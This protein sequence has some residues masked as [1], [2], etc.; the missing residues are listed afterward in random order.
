MLLAAAVP[1]KEA[2]RVA[3]LHDLGL[4]DTPDEPAF[5]S[6]VQL[7]AHVCN[8]P[9]ALVSLVDEHRQWFKA[10]IGFDV[11]ETAREV[12]FCTY[13]ILENRMLEVCD[14]H[15]DPRFADN[16]LVTGTSRFRFYAGVPIHTRDGIALGTVCVI[17]LVPRRLDAD[18]RWML[19]II[20]EQVTAQIELRRS[21]ADIADALRARDDERVLLCSVLQSATAYGLI[22]TTPNGTINVFSRG[23]EKLLG[24]SADEVVGRATP[25]LF[26]LEDEVASRAA[27]LGVEDRFE[28]FVE[29]ARRGEGE[30]QEWTW[31]RKD[32]SRLPVGLTVTAM[33]NEANKL[34]GFIGIGQDL[35]EERRAALERQR[36]AEE[37]RA[38]AAAD[39]AVD[40]LTRLQA[41]AAALIPTMTS[42]QV[43]EIMKQQ[44]SSIRV[45]GGAFSEE[46]Q[47]FL[48][49]LEHLGAQALDRA[50]AHEA[51]S[52]AHRATEAA[53]H[54]KEEF[55]AVLSHELRT[56]LTAVLGWAHLLRSSPVPPTAIDAARLQRGL[57][58]IENNATTLLGAVEAILDVQRIVAG[59]IELSC[60]LVDLGARV[61]EA[62]DAVKPVAEAAGLTLTLSIT[63]G[64]LPIR[65]DPARLQQIVNNLLANAIKFTPRGGRIDVGVDHTDSQLRLT[66]A[67]TGEG[68]SPDFLPRMFE[69]GLQADSSRTRAHG[70]LG[71]GLAIVKHLVE[72]HGGTVTA[73]SG[74]LGQ[75]ARVTVLLPVATLG[76]G[77]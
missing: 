4:L 5:D 72:L 29:S 8:T 32:G 31:L 39:R 10:R 47:L 56:P 21:F 51:E 3:A 14:A 19:Q 28:V 74:G 43:V 53:N 59:N 69:R 27:E 23:A 42:R 71:I 1:S 17:D 61:R 70:G 52:A 63:P 13:T 16:P 77:D 58:V 26:H 33:R 44:A 7:A 68:I 30:R 36:L 48:L 50:R 55:L 45:E 2:E 11:R 60:A 34:I 6:L 66:V 18:Q 12:A 41:A 35:T 62:V 54:A 9:I 25:L 37:R 57:A 22:A 76:V 65:A 75:G 38:R 67:D 49:A 64:S 15:L 24:Y 40:R 46:E 73:E 20:A